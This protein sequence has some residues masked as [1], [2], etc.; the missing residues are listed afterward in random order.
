MAVEVLHDRILCGDV[1]EEMRKLPDESVH[2]VITSPPYTGDS[3]IMDC[4]RLSGM[5]TPPTA[6]TGGAIKLRLARVILADSASVGSTKR[7][8]KTTPK[9]GKNEPSKV[10][11]A[12]FVVLGVV[13]LV[14]NLT[15]SRPTTP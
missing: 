11:S 6:S 15:R 14:S 5:A 12:A 9:P 7:T 8:A 13:H 10:S 2:C 4:P 3:E 1:L